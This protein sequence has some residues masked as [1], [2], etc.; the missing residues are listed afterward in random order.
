[1]LASKFRLLWSPCSPLAAGA[2]VNVAAT[3]TVQA[4]VLD[5]TAGA[6]L[7]GAA[8]RRGAQPSREAGPAAVAAVG[9]PDGRDEDDTVRDDRHLD[10]RHARAVRRRLV[11]KQPPGAASSA[12]LEPG[13]AVGEELAASRRSLAAALVIQAPCGRPP[14]VA[15]GSSA[16]IAEGTM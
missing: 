1:M 16:G 4:D 10:R 5:D 6:T 13:C 11:G 2:A 14:G 12:Q 8:D 15:I 3:V 9:P 7:C